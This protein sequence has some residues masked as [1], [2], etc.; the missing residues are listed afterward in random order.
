MAYVCQLQRNYWD[1]WF[2][3]NMFKMQHIRKK[4]QLEDDQP[5]EGEEGSKRYLLVGRGSKVL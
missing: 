2:G 5:W 3:E 4:M 1:Q